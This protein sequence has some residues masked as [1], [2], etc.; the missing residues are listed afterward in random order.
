MCIDVA[1]GCSYL[2]EMHLV[3]RD[4][5]S[6]NCLVSFSGPNDLIIKIGDF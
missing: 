6:R 1:E 2:E 5:A 3:H 4:I